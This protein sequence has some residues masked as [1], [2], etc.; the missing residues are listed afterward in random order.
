MSLSATLAAELAPLPSRERA[1]DP[2]RNPSQSRAEHVPNSLDDRYGS[3]GCLRVRN[4]CILEDWRING[5]T[6]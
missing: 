1:K 4:R 6:I 3:L 5:L 2:L